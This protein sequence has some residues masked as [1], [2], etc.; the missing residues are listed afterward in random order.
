MHVHTSG[1]VLRTHRHRAVSV[2]ATHSPPHWAVR[3]PARAA[4]L[5]SVL[6]IQKRIGD[7]P[8]VACT[9]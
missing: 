1:A 2:T 4:P 5:P 7:D 3:C 9:H 6:Y 8:I